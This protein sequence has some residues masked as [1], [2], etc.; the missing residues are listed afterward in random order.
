MAL[1][2]VVQLCSHGMQVA[3]TMSSYLLLGSQPPGTDTQNRSSVVIS[4]DMDSVYQAF[5]SLGVIL[6]Y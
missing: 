4:Y 6:S 1:L 2:D 5:S 3:S